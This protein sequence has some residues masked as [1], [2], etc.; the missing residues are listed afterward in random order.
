L[1]GFEGMSSGEMDFKGE[2]HP[3]F[4]G[5]RFVGLTQG[6]RSCDGNFPLTLN[7]PVRMLFMGGIAH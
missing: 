4:S 7:V 6:E 3:D 5:L 1:I 2:I